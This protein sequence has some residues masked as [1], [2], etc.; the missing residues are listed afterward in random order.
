MNQP[1][2]RQILAREEIR[3]GEYRDKDL[4]ALLEALDLPE[5]DLLAV[6]I[7][8]D[9]ANGKNG[10]IVKGLYPRRVMPAAPGMNNRASGI[11]EG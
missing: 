9:V 8:Y 11:I 7:Q 4:K 10:M 2:Q 5:N 6:L 1:Q 3:T